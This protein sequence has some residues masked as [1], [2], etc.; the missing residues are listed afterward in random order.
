M[1]WLSKIVWLILLP[2]NMMLWLLVAALLLGAFGRWRA[3][4]WCLTPVAAISVA[5]T[6]LPVG[7]WLL[8]PLEDRFER[9]EITSVGRVD[10]IIVLGGAIDP[11]LS[12]SRNDTA[13]NSSAERITAMIALAHAHPDVPVVFSGGS[14]NPF[15]QSRREADMVERFLT[16]IGV[17]IPNLILERASRNTVENARYS[18]R[19]VKPKEGQRWLLITSAAHM[20]R[21]VGVFRDVGWPVVPFPVDYRTSGKWTWRGSFSLS[22]G[23]TKIDVAAKE[24]IGLVAYRLLGRTKDLLPGPRNEK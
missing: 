19:L 18:F 21:A 5:A 3:A 17:K 14:G 8:L 23:L 20:P 2:S 12:A 24:W 13:L 7:A 6:L 15:D 4:L 22:R 1:F 10:G 9:R 11:V 16:T